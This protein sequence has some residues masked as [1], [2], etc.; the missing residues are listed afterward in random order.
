MSH[1]DIVIKGGT[2]IDGIRTP[3]YKADLGIK[4][5]VITQ[6][7]L[8]H[9]SEGDEV[10]DA[11][12]KVV[13][14]GVV[15]IHTHY[16][17]QLFWD[18]WCTMSGWHGVTT[19]VLGNCGFGFAPCKLEDQDRTM[20]SLSRNE[21]VPL[22]TMRAGMPWDWVTY[23]EFLDSVDRT[24][25]G[26]N[27]MS[28]VPLAPL[29]TYV[30]G[31]EKTKADR[32]SD[33]ELDQM[34]ELLIEAMEAG[35]CG[36]SSQISGDLFN[37]QLDY[38]GTPM[39]TDMMTERE[40]TAFSR[41]L[42]TLGRGTTQ[43]TGQLETAALIARESGRPIIWNALAPTGSVSQHGESQYPHRETIARLD[44]LNE[45]EGLRVFA[46]AQIVRFQSEIV[47]E[48]YNLMDIF[49]AW[50]EAGLGTLEEK[51]AKFSDPERRPDLRAA[52]DERG[53]GFGA[54]RYPLAEITVNWISSDARDA[55]ALKETY[56]GFTIGEIAEREGKHLGDALL[57]IAVAGD[58][59][60]GFGT[61]MID[62]DTAAVK[63]VANCSVAL[64]GISDGGAHTKFVTTARFAT[65]LLGHWVRD[66]EVMSLEEAHW[67]LSA[68]PAQAVGLRDRGWLAEGKPADI[69][70]YDPDKVGAGPQERLFDYPADEWRLVQ[71]AVGYDRIIVNGTIT[72]ENGVCTNATPGKL[73]RHGVA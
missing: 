32:A 44:E 9:P 49:P 45:K 63:E 65:E 13:A 41:A 56:E 12:D 20:L 29:Y 31:I 67:R 61:T 55:L 19:V 17:S 70:I 52:I 3:R 47:L 10:I 24:P 21:A 39:V 43:I 66:H 37:V 34:C 36:W 5:G 68:Y 26:V 59:N 1:Y 28:L 62:M 54:A 71:K 72:F 33:E 25:K 42:R 53:G 46:S 8:I 14:P 51:I 40:I 57:D 2:V 7:G 4:D 48:N 50:K 58:L 11:S 30:V 73:L 18:P 16:D 6:I 15:D 35:G 22:K 60:V 23:P 64:P 27:V 69:I 38:D